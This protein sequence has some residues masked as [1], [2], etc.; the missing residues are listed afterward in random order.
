MKGKNATQIKF[1]MQVTPVIGRI[2]SVASLTPNAA[3]V[4]AVFD[5]P[6]HTFLS[7]NPEVYSFRDTKKSFGDEINYRLHFFQCGEYLVWGLTAGILVEAAKIALGRNAEFQTM[8]PGNR[9]YSE[10]IYD[11]EL[12]RVAYRQHT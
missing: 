8:P 10:I 11:Y 12:D 4:D 3:E 5:V 9:E 7:A 6:L 2:A 1:F